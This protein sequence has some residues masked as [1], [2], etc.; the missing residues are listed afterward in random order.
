MEGVPSPQLDC[1]P[2]SDPMPSVVPSTQQEFTQWMVMESNIG[3]GFLS[4]CF[5]PVTALCKFF[6]SSQQIYAVG[7][8]L[9]PIL[10][11]S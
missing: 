7:T 8:V 9:T 10:E 1:Q 5:V 2:H 11:M 4:P 6:L 3:E